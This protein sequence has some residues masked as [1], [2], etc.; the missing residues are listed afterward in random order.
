VSS[1]Y[2][3]DG[4]GKILDFLHNTAYSEVDFWETTLNYLL[5]QL[6]KNKKECTYLAKE[7]NRKDQILREVKK[8]L[9]I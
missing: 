6:Q 9:S 4:F 2:I 8:E 3:N 1:E 7:S 5:N